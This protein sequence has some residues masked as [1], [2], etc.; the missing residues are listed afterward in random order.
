MDIDG[1]DADTVDDNERGMWNGSLGHHKCI[2]WVLLPQVKEVA[3]K[4]RDEGYS[5]FHKDIFLRTII[6]HKVQPVLP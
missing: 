5:Q 4:Q 6:A 1:D 2:I 3:R